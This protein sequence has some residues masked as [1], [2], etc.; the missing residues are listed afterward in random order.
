MK[1]YNQI[2]EDIPK[3]CTVT[4]GFFDGVHLGHIFL[5]NELIKTGK[6]YDCPTLVITMWPHPQTVIYDKRIKLIN[7]PD[8]KTELIRKTG[9]DG[10]LILDFSQELAGLSPKKFIEYVL[11]NKLNAKI[12]LKGFNNSFGNINKQNEVTGNGRIKIIRAGKFEFGK[13]KNINSTLIRNYLSNGKVEQANELLGYNYTIK[14]KVSSGHKVGRTLGFPTGNVSDI[15]PVKLIP[16]T[17]VYVIKAKIEKSY[18]PAMLNIGYRP[19]FGSNKKTL[20]FHIINFKKSIYNQNVELVFYK[21]IRDE[22]K[23]ENIDMLIEQLKKDKMITESY[24]RENF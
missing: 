14:G 5:I 1:I 18:F 11:V 15:N 19:S 13:H 8:E 20:E 23:F 21:K 2:N 24:F 10:L 9:A 12:L 6:K 22:I 16:Q 4:V 17:G 3:H 7:D